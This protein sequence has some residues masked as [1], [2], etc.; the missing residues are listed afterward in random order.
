MKKLFI[1][2]LLLAFSAISTQ[3]QLEVDSLG[4]VSILPAVNGWKPTLKIGNSTNYGAGVNIKNVGQYYN[5]EVTRT[6]CDTASVGILINMDN[7]HNKTT[8]LHC[9]AQGGSNISPYVYGVSTHVYGGIK[10]IGVFGKAFNYGSGSNISAVGIYGTSQN[11]SEASISYP[12]HYGGYFNGNV[13][14]VSG[15]IY[16]TLVTPATISGG[17]SSQG[18]SV[19]M[20]DR[21]G[22]DGVTGKLAQVQTI[23]F[24][25][26]KREIGDELTDEKRREKKLD[27]RPSII[28]YG[29][30]ADQLKEVYPELVYE[31]VEGN[32]SIN[33]IEM[34]PLLVQSINELSSELAELKG[35]SNRKA[36]TKTQATAIEDATD[37]IDQVRMDQN[38]PNPFSGSTVITLSVPKK[39]KQAAIYIYDLSGKQVES[40]PV[41]ERGKTNITFYANN[42]SAG[43]YIYSLVVDGQVKVTRRMMITE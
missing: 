40:V 36:K 23:Q 6:L 11:I 29:L 26:D 9:S 30:A 3:A 4:R 7:S 18:V 24:L 14:V 43:M 1:F 32:V 35:T 15:S 8:A 12:G 38:K 28:Q 34:I 31:D 33:Y 10:T 17:G 25:R 13:R 20:L 27:P 19:I 22:G 2:G 16:G 41:E 5:L 42:L 37:D 21:D 39:A